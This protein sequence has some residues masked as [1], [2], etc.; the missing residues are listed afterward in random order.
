MNRMDADACT[1]GNR[2]GVHSR[3]PLVSSINMPMMIIKTLT[4]KRIRYLLSVMLSRASGNLSRHVLHRQRL[5]EDH[6][7]EEH[8]HNNTS[9]TGG[10]RQCLMQAVPFRPL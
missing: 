9:G 8:H 3:M 4:I 7:H 5:A 2:M 6:D 1:I 10:F